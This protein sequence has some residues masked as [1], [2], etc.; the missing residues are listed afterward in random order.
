M[1]WT[2]FSD[3]PVTPLL[4]EPLF[5]N[6]W[7]AEYGRSGWVDYA[8]MIEDAKKRGCSASHYTLDEILNN[9]QAGKNGRKITKAQI[10]KAYTCESP[11]EFLEWSQRRDVAFQEMVVDYG[12][13]EK[14]PKVKKGS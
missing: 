12:P 10:I 13:V 3:S 1:Q 5:Q 8:N 4:P 2:S 6:Y 9:N 14:R 7:Y 11:E